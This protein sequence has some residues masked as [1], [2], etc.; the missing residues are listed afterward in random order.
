MFQLSYTFHAVQAVSHAEKSIFHFGIFDFVCLCVCMSEH[1]LKTAWQTF[2]VS[3]IISMTHMKSRVNAKLHIEV[4]SVFLLFNQIVVC[5][6]QSDDC[7]IGTG[8]I[9]WGSSVVIW[10][11]SNSAHWITEENEI[12]KHHHETCQLWEVKLMC[13]WLKCG[14][15]SLWSLWIPQWSQKF[16]KHASLRVV[17][18]VIANGIFSYGR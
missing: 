8:S 9:L 2:R 13:R 3:I 18:L 6:T 16:Y 4:T 1:R 15:I 12:L 10:L 7:K 5:V 17:E 14:P 11:L